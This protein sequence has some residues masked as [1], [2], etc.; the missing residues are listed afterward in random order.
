MNMKATFVLLLCL[1]P[2]VAYTDT[3]KSD[4]ASERFDC[5][6]EPLL[7]IAVGSPVQGVIKSIDVAR[8]DLVSKGQVLAQLNS[9]VEEASLQ[10]ARVRASMDGE[11][12]ARMADLQLAKHLLSRTN[13]LYEKKM[14]SSQQLDEAKAE[15]EVARMA[16]RQAQ[17]RKSLSQQELQ[18]AK[19]VVDRRTIVSPIDGVVVE[20]H[21]FPGEFVY[22]NPIVKIAQIDPLRVEVLIPSDYYGEL[23]PGMSAR[24]YPELGDGKGFAA[25]VAI[26]DRMIDTG[27]STFGTQL[28][29][30][31]PDHMI[32]SGQ[33]CEI[34]FS[35]GPDDYKQLAHAEQP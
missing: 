1:T 35:T 28:E 7:V 15:H 5:L 13:E 24:I 31:N 22:D 21:A 10:Q 32:P 2:G 30:P 19:E 25:E 4:I 23:K 11:I 29:L 27:S 14:V 12:G 18:W 26:V 9:S 8:S 33:K 16:V 6:I 17:E 3:T 34:V 20:P